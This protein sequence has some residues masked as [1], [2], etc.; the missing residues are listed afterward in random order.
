MKCNLN[1]DGDCIQGTFLDV[2]L[3]AGLT[4][5]IAKNLIEGKEFKKV[6]KLDYTQ[7]KF[8]EDEILGVCSLIRKNL[9]IT[10]L[11]LNSYKKLRNTHLQLIID[12]LDANTN[13]TEIGF[14]DFFGDGKTKNKIAAILARNMAIAKLRKYVLDYPLIHTASFALDPLNIIVDK[15][16]VSYIVNGISKRKTKKAID[17]LLLGASFYELETELKKSS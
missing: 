11:I 4:E 16:I 6:M 14:L 13:L 8:S 5:F 15:T 3:S 17:E 2:S 10:S 7:I 9:K 12:A 1:E